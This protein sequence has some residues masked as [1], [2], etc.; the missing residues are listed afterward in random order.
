MRT[1]YL[2]TITNHQKKV[3]FEGQVFAEECGEI[4]NLVVK[5]GRV[6]S[7]RR[8]AGGAGGKDVEREPK[9]TI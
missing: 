4:I 1:Y 7:I 8:V 2:V 9:H 5:M 6:D 3:I